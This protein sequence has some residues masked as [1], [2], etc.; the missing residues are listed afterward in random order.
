MNCSSTES[1]LMGMMSLLTRLI[2]PE[3]PPWINAESI[4]LQPIPGV[5]TC[6]PSQLGG[7]QKHRRNEKLQPNHSCVPSHLTAPRFTP[8]RETASHTPAAIKQHATTVSNLSIQQAD[9]KGGEAVQGLRGRFSPPINTLQWQTGLL[10]APVPWDMTH[11]EESACRLAQPSGV[12]L[13]ASAGVRLLERNGETCSAS[14]P[15]LAEGEGGSGAH[16]GV[17]RQGCISLKRAIFPHAAVPS[18]HCGSVYDAVWMNE[19]WVLVVQGEQVEG[20]CFRD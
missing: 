13:L 7:N 5:S 20:S 2:G 18:C 6:K 3:S 19:K 14:D 11:I 15:D 1:T 10:L 9:E 8:I 16:G 17:A 12:N 4:P